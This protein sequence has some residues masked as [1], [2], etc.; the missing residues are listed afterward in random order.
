ML[1]NFSKPQFPYLQNG[2]KWLGTRN[3]EDESKEW[4]LCCGEE[5]D[6]QEQLE[7]H[8]S[9]SNGVG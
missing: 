4:L 9:G 1:F 3:A 8:P 6:K 2:G 5:K 7:R